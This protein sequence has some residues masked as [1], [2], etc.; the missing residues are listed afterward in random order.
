MFLL[1]PTALAAPIL[2]TVEELA[3]QVELDLPE[4]TAIRLTVG[5]LPSCAAEIAEKRVIFKAARC[6]ALLTIN[7]GVVGKVEYSVDHGKTDKV[8]EIALAEATGLGSLH[9]GSLEWKA[10]LDGVSTG[11]AWAGG[12]WSR[13]AIAE[14]GVKSGDPKVQLAAKTAVGVRFHDAVLGWREATL[15]PRPKETPSCANA[16][17]PRGLYNSRLICVDLGASASPVTLAGAT[18]AAWFAR[19]E[20]LRKA[21]T[22]LVLLPG[23]WVTVV[24]LNAPGLVSATPSAGGVSIDETSAVKLVDEKAGTPAAGVQA[25][26]VQVLHLAPR[27]M[28]KVWSLVLSSGTGDKARGAALEFEVRNVYVGAVRLGVAMTGAYDPDYELVSW[29]ETGS[30]TIED[31]RKN[32]FALTPE[33]VVGYSAFFHPRSY[34]FGDGVNLDRF[35]LYAGL[36][37]LAFDGGSLDPLH[38]AYLGVE[39]EPLPDFGITLAAI[40]R[41]GEVLDHPYDEGDRVGTGV[42]FTTM[43]VRPGVALVLNLSPAFFRAHPTLNSKLFPAS[44]GAK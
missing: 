31:S 6:P 36:G 25:P 11:W 29:P 38:S 10:A 26:G 13:V 24:V 37:V 28:G 9:I 30:S 17:L 4:A 20:T 32:A 3:T 19:M 8:A 7:A 14:D 5:N 21:D 2:F 12:R 23:E 43:A 34:T 39:W 18:D 27:P 44:G 35:G 41:R 1:V 40:A 16:T 33:V 42:S 22:G 15:G